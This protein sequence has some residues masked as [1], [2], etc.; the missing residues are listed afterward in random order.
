M[1]NRRNIRLRNKDG[2]RKLDISFLHVFG[3]LC[4]P[5]NDHED[6]GKLGAKGDIGFFI[7]YSAD[8]CAYRIY[9]RRTKKIMETINVSFDELLAMAFEQRSSKL[10]LQRMTSRQISSGL[11]LTYAPSTITKQQPSEGELDLLFEAMYD[12]YFGG[13]P[14]ANVKNVPPAQE[15]QVRQTS[16]TS[17]TIA[18]N[19]PIPT[20]SSSHATIIPITSQDVNELNPNAMID[21]NTFVNPFATSSSNTA[22]TSPSQNVNPSNMHTFYQPYPHEFQ[23]TKDHPLEQVIGEPS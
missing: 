14:S 17:T 11:D 18:D 13:Q 2:G 1:N 22:E 23:W 10:G 5:K 8:S 6:I 21:G 9:N 4:Y 15:P 7:G 20:N 12:D 3:A 16:T 19:V